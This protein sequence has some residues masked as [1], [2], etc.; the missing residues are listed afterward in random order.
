MPLAG[1]PLSRQARRTG[2]PVYDNNY[3]RRNSKNGAL[4][5]PVR[6]NN[7]LAVPL[8][9]EGKV[10]G[11]LALD[12]KPRGFTKHDVK[13]ASVLGGL[14]GVALYAGRKMELLRESE[15]RFRSLVKAATDAVICVDDR[16]NVIL[17]N[18]GAQSIFGYS[19]AEMLGKPVTTVVPQRARKAHHERT[20]QLASGDA[21]GVVGG[22]IEGTGLRKDGTE[23]PIEISLSQWET[24]GRAFITVIVRDITVRKRLEK[25]ILEASVKEQQRIGQDLHDSLCQEL[26]GVEY[27]CRV[28][29]KKL[30]AKSV[31]EAADAARIGELINQSMT[32]ARGL[33]KGLYLV[34]LEAGGLKSAIR[35]WISSIEEEF[36]VSCRVRCDAS[37]DICDGSVARNIYSIVQEAVRN[38]IKHGGAKHISIRLCSSNR[39]FTL[40]VK[41][42][43]TGISDVAR[44]N[45]GMGLHIMER[46]ARMIDGLFSVQ[47]NA[48][49]GTTVRCQV[50]TRKH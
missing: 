11:V 32:Q 45:G 12:N 47:R 44:S 41:D 31:V 23:L 20:D 39:G 34:E 14:V 29:Q 40:S 15:K 16:G 1:G 4:Q 5:I 6:L 35:K 24:E 7:V 3:G 49:G 18:D 17:W 9:I 48:D 38:A 33:A 36:D 43:G 28:L 30:S 42:D 25:G 2:K 37:F 46:R 10:G 8:M 50:R 27:L 22:H 21:P 26:A 19:A 13:I